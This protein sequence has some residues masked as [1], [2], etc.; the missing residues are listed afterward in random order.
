MAT[1][2]AAMTRASGRMGPA[3]DEKQ[4]SSVSE[5][6]SSAT[7][8]MVTDEYALWLP[9][10]A[11]CAAV[12]RQL[13]VYLLNSAYRKEGIRRR[14]APPPSAEPAKKTESPHPLMKVGGR[15]KQGLVLGER[16]RRP[17]HVI[18]SEPS[19]LPPLLPHRG[20]PLEFRVGA[21]TVL[22]ELKAK[23]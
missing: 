5:A 2:T 3:A 6:A 14:R 21:S 7:P 10:A 18:F 13:G 20:Q 22:D 12:R 9:A 11:S 19:V 23:L 16:K 1:A 8:S 17:G 15:L 4:I